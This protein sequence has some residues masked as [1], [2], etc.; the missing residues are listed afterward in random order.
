[1]NHATDEVRRWQI[2]LRL[3]R[4][5]RDQLDELS[6]RRNQPYSAAI[7]DLIAEAVGA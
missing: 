1:M 4:H 7:R 5:E 2:N 6:K 3:N